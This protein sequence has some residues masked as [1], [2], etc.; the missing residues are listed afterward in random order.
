MKEDDH[1]SL[2]ESDVVFQDKKQTTVDYQR[3]TNHIKESAAISREA[4]VS[5]EEATVIIHPDY[6]ELPV[7][8]MW[9]T[10]VHYGSMGVDYDMLDRHLEIIMSTPNTYVILGGDMVDNFS[11]VKHPVAMLGDA[12]G[13]QLQT[14]AFL[15]RVKEVDRKS[16]LLAI[17][18]G[19]HE[20]FI[21][22]A[23]YDYW[24]TFLHDIQAP[25]FSANGL[26]NVNVIRETY[27]LAVFHKFWGN[28]KINPANR[29]KRAMEYGGYSN[30]DVVLI[31]DDHLY[32]AED[33]EKNGEERSVIDGGTYKIHDKTGSRWGLG[34]AGRPGKSL[35]LFPDRHH[36]ELTK[37]PE[38]LQE[39]TDARVML[40]NAKR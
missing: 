11:P 32:V 25:I 3:I 22:Q 30:V 20:E 17:G 36:W 21:A 14:Q 5:Q 13:P 38:V 9:M 4:D 26:V 23:G 31:G 6:P 39:I 1:N 16:K 15:E 12:I 34:L 33:F 37:D 28:S 7:H 29:P 35:C 24:N 8:V 18:Y 2:P 40:L 27:R 10:D 19:N